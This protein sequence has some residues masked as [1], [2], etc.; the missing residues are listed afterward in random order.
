MKT[1]WAAC[2]KIS[3]CKYI[4]QWTDGK[5][6]LRKS[7]DIYDPNPVLLYVEFN[8]PGNMKLV[9]YSFHL[10]FLYCIIDTNSYYIIFL[11]SIDQGPE[12]FAFDGCSKFKKGQAWITV[13][14][15]PSGFYKGNIRVGNIVCCSLDGSSCSRK[16]S[17]DICRSGKND[18][19]KKVTWDEANQHC[20]SE[21]K[22]L[23]KSQ[24]ELNRCCDT[25]CGYDHTLVWSSLKQGTTRI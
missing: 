2:K 20:A 7:D 24:E 3:G 17:A 11:Q 15:K 25:G 14:S 16:T 21:G 4:M 13:P 9:T 10:N 8:C 5:F 23:C 18:D 12:Y 22:R 19:M 1:A 6:Q